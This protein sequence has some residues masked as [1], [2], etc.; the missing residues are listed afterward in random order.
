[1]YTAKAYL[2]INNVVLKTNWIASWIVPC[3]ATNS[4]WKIE[5]LERQVLFLCI[6]YTYWSVLSTIQWHPSIWPGRYSTVVSH[7]P[8]G[9]FSLSKARYSMGN[10]QVSSLQ[11]ASEMEPQ[12][13]VQ[14]RWVVTSWNNSC[15][16]RLIII[17]LLKCNCGWLLPL[18]SYGNA[19]SNSMCNFVMQLENALWICQF[20]MQSG[21][22][23]LYL[24]IF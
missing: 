22:A 17:R 4:S 10:K 16:N 2:S 11:Y 20:N 15:N 6:P 8:Q 9:W 13:L 24:V 7:Y 21:N 12:I 19:F 3:C 18:Y 23:I 14:A 1:M 5:V